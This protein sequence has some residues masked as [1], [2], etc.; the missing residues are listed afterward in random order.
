MGI[1]HGTN[2]RRR[3][4]V[5]QQDYLPPG[6]YPPPAFFDNL[7][8]YWQLDEASGTGDRVSQVNSSTYD[9][10]SQ[11]S[12]DAVAAFR[13]NGVTPET[14]VY[15]YA[16]GPAFSREHAPNVAFSINLWAKISTATNTL[17]P[18]FV[19]VDG[20]LRAS[21]S[22]QDN[23]TRNTWQCSVN[24]ISL[25]GR[26]ASIW[27][28][29][30]VNGF[31]LS[32]VY[33]PKKNGSGGIWRVWADADNRNEI[34]G[35]SPEIAVPNGH[36]I[37]HKGSGAPNLPTNYWLVANSNYLNTTVVDEFGVWVGYALTLEDRKWLLGDYTAGALQR[38]LRGAE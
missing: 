10:T 35:G 6:Y 4:P 33:S 20:A 31:M 30:D 26:L 18:W 2:L 12:M 17:A 15:L 13:G 29:R 19:Y 27:L 23:T 37:F 7:E 36:D 16:N 32:A 9:L 25:G 3:S 38:P 14:G 24:D 1:F 34:P 11:G 5:V 8:S 22:L 28:T 21:A